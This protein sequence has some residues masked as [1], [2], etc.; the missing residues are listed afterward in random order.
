MDLIDE[1][2]EAYA[3]AYDNCDTSDKDG[4]EQYRLM[5]QCIEQYRRETCTKL[6][7]SLNKKTV[8]ELGK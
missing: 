7:K 5:Q 1:L 3:F 4:M 2:D 8:A 6:M